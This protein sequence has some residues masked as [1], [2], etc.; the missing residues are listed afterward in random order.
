MKHTVMFEATSETT[1]KDDPDQFPVRTGEFNILDLERTSDT[2]LEIIGTRIF[3]DAKPI[4][5]RAASLTKSSAYVA[6]RD[7]SGLS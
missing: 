4:Q 2:D 7:S 6:T 1:S 3:L 5:A